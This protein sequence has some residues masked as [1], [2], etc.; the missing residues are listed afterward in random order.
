M[1]CLLVSRVSS[2]LTIPSPKTPAPGKLLAGRKLRGVPLPAAAAA[3]V[4]AGVACNMAQR[5]LA[6]NAPAGL[7]DDDGHL[8]LVVE[9]LGFLR[10][11]HRLAAADLAVGEAGEDHRMRRRR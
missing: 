9:A 5:R 2:G 11:E 3:V 10:P 4:V 6:R 7:A 1:V 8:A